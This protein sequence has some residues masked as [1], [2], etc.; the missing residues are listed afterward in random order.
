[1]GAGARG[2]G[3]CDVGCVPCEI[4]HRIAFVHG[5]NVGLVAQELN[6]MAK[7]LRKS[8]HCLSI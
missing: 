5:Y 4:R 6:R 7:P 2:V 1:M 3:I 8:G